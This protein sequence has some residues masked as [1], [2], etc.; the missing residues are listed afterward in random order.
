MNSRRL[1]AQSLLHVTNTMT[2]NANPVSPVRLWTGRI[3]SGLVIAFLLFDAAGKIVLIQPV[4]E[5]MKHLGFPDSPELARGLGLL[6]L[7]C[8]LLY[9]VPRT[10]LVGAVL[11][12]GYLGGAIAIH[13]RAGHP[14][15]THVLFG[16]Y[17]GVLL[18]VGLWLGNRNARLLF[19]LWC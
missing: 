3:L 8:T 16:G 4:I 6:L 19:R 7:A 1:Y 11:L 9:A 14:L 12:T 13:L 5:G 18:W 2:P 17:I 10:S 15:L